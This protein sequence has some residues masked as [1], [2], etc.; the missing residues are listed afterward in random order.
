MALGIVKTI[1]QLLICLAQCFEVIR[2]QPEYKAAVWFVMGK[3]FRIVGSG[4]WDQQTVTVLQMITF[5]SHMVLYIAFQEKI[6]FII[7]V[8]MGSHGF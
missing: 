1:S 4:G 6:E 2:S 3:K 5:V 8:F 7:I